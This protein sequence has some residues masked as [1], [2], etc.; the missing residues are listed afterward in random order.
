M[1]QN[2]DG[3]GSRPANWLPESLVAEICILKNSSTAALEK[4]ASM[5]VQILGGSGYMTGSKSERIFREA[6]VL[7][8]GGGSTEIMKD[9]AARQLRL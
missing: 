8:I 6:K 4:V 7:Q 5:A 9:L 1:Q 3:C 2:M